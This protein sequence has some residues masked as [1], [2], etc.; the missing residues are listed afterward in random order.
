MIA[1][2][3]VVTD[4][5]A[6]LMSLSLTLHPVFLISARV[7]LLCVQCVDTVSQVGTGSNQMTVTGVLSSNW[8][9][10]NA[11]MRRVEKVLGGTQDPQFFTLSL[12]HRHHKQYM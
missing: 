11:T 7:T 2:P 10:K 5:E 9:G 12:G 8:V 6:V 4:A 1:P 3:H